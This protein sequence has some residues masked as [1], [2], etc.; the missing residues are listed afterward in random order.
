[1]NW[2]LTVMKNYAG[3]SGRARRK[4]YWMFFLIYVLIYLAVSIVGTIVL[5]EN[6]TVPIG[7]VALVHL[8]P[9]IAVGIR[10]MHDTNH[11]GWWL[12]VP[13]VNLFFAFTEGTRGP[14]QY[15]PDPKAG[16]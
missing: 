8:L 1:M 3:F 11:A 2:Y 7:L 13:L 16:G 14:N 10:R 4:E 12:L 9:G 6:A 5:G 15:G